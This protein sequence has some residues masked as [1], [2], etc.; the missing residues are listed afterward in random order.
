MKNILRVT[1]TSVVLF[2]LVGSISC[3]KEKCGCEGEEKF[4]LTEE[5]GFI[6]YNEET[7]YA[8]W[9]PKYTYGN[10][11][12][13]DPADSWDLITSFDSGEEVLVWGTVKDDCMAQMNPQ[14]YSGYYVLQ[15]E[16]MELN[17]FGH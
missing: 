14:Y 6:S 3:K 7:K 8:T 13:C 11:T 5:V 17:E 16:K 1:I 4:S 9:I 10:F 15:I 12:I 2:F